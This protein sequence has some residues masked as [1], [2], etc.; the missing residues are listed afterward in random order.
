MKSFPREYLLFDNFFA[1][2]DI[3]GVG[4]HQVT[5]LGSEINLSKRPSRARADN[6][7]AEKNVGPLP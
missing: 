3:S 4:G 5:G 2:R 1:T 6:H 7:R